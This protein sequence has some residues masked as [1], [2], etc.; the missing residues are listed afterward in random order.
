MSGSPAVQTSLETLRRELAGAS[1]PLT[2]PHSASG[3]E[4]SADLSHQLSDYIV[5]RY[6]TLDAPLLAVVGGSTGSGKSTLVN[7]LVGKTVSAASAIRPTTRRP[8]LVCHR[9]EKAWFEGDR[10]L[11][12]LARVAREGESSGSGDVT[13]LELVESEALPQGIALLDS[14]DIDSVVEENRRLA[15][16]LLA[17]A[18]L[19]IF[20]TTAARYA[21]AIPWALLDEAAA[22]NIVIAVVLNRVPS[23]V[24]PQIRPDL[25]A[26]LKERGLERAPLFVISEAIDSDGFIPAENVAALKGWLDGLTRDAAAR[27]SVARQTLNGAVHN[28]FTGVRQ[29]A[30][31]LEEQ[32]REYEAMSAGISEAVTGARGAVAYALDDGTLLRGEVLARWQEIVGTGEWMKRLESGVSSVRD[33]VSAWFHGRARA[34]EA[35]RMEASVEESVSAL[36]LSEGE[37]CVGTVRR[38]WQLH[39]SGS[40]LLAAV[41]ISEQR[42]PNARAAAATDAVRAWQREL[43]DL[44]A[45]E[46]K[47]KRATARMVSVGVNLL[48]VA[49]M[50]AVFASTA[51]LTG[52]EMAI[53]GGTAVLAQRILEA[54]FG[55]DAVRRMV[56]Q[57]QDSL[58][59]RAAHFLD[60]DV[61]PYRRIL[62]G[63]G[64]DTGSPERLAAAL[65]DST[66][67]L[68]EE[69]QA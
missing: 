69:A 18:D 60:D 26:R 23:G 68:R 65:S 64:V 38:S 56:T 3:A 33:R 7:S 46:G 34:V 40:T 63:L 32:N 62:A 43:V 9:G 31:A 53:A 24:G 35:D 20:V 8:V 57:A 55:D 44:I 45:S 29:V 67:A 58:L 28:L 41:D 19:W 4:L 27:A 25:A 54:V 30:D 5:P 21:D 1:F 2:T 59:D 51:G 50:I 52:S 48:G 13:E 15:S 22:R 17:A 42:D 16:E 49:L 39:P 47:G 14:P 66:R 6:R 11:P 12:R 37:M 61:E 36:L 10:I